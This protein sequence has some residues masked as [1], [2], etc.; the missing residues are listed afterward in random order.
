MKIWTKDVD[1]ASLAQLENVARLPFVFHHVAAMPDVHAGVGATIGSVIATKGAVVPSALGE[2]IGCGMALMRTTLERT[3]VREK[4]LGRIW[5]EI[6]KRIPVGFAQ[7][8]GEAVRTDLVR[9]L[10]P[11][12]GRILAKRP[13]VLAPMRASDWWR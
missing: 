4:T 2:D 12:L 10:E 1:A 5:S 6:T 13:D 11:G 7:R 9:A 8:G 3:G